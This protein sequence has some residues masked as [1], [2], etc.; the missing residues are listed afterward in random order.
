MERLI[1]PEGHIA[2]GLFE[3]PVGRIEYADYALMSPMGRRIGRVGKHF[4]AHQFNFFGFA[5]PRWIGGVAVVDLRY[6]SSAF[7][8]VFD[9]QTGVLREVS[10]RSP[11]G[12]AIRPTPDDPDS[13][14]RSRRLR[15]AITAGHVEAAGP[16]FAFSFSVAP[17]EAPP[18][19][20]CTR[21][22]YRGWQFTRKSGGFALDGVLTFD[23]VEHSL[24]SSE[25]RGLSDWSGGFMRRETSWNW[26]AAAGVLPDGRPFGLNLACVVNETGWT[27]N[28]FWVGGRRVKLESARFEYDESDLGK[29][30]RVRSSDGLVDLVFT[31]ESRH[32]ERASAGLVATSFSQL[33]GAYSGTVRLPE[34]GAVAVDGITGW[35]EDHYAKW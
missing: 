30:W 6:L 5:G 26:A 16:G 29:P 4:R 12:A 15:A 20:L 21:C 17:P 22:G 23:G 31:P 3:E 25:C 28:A 19:R 27:E 9:R 2:W 35:A 11:A 18:L 8:Y 1:G 33:L 24:G 32:C 7:A 10:A 14:Y 13:R 34:G